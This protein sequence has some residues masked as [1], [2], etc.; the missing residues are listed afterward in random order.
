MM[1]KRKYYYAIVNKENGGLL[2]AKASLPIY[3][4]KEIAIHEA[5]KYEGY[6]VSK[7]PIDSLE[8]LILKSPISTST[9]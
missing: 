8:R 3:W 4:V 5:K 2:V 1:S 7:L 6:V 9:P